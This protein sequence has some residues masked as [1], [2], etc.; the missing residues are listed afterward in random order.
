[1]G[2]WGP[3]RR[4][5]E[6]QSGALSSAEARF[7]PRRTVLVA[8]AQPTFRLGMSAALEDGGFVVVAQVATSPEAITGA[9]AGRP[10]LCVLD[11][12]MPG[13]AVDAARTITTHLAGTAVLMVTDRV[14]EAELLGA[15]RA[16]ASGYLPKST[17]PARLRAAVHAALGGDTAIPR[18]LVVSMIDEIRAR[19][20]RRAPAWLTDHDVHLTRRESQVVELLRGA[21]ATRDIAAELGISEI[22]V[23]RHLSEALRKLGARDRTSALGLLA[24]M[25]AA[26]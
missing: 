20:P 1:M 17:D 22:T 2:S 18:P 16:G 14:Q 24:D 3:G 4:A 8:D 19:Q 6:G 7:V 9:I 15:L 12:S 23:R 21:L 11:C 13:G 25:Q 10:D 26:G 5:A